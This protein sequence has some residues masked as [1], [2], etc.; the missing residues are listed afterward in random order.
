MDLL[1]PS[2]RCMTLSILLS[3]LSDYYNE[4]NEDTGLHV[5]VSQFDP[6]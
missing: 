1:A 5:V 4:A 6:T 2:D 3:R